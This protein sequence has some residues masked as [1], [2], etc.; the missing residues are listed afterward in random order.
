MDTCFAKM[1]LRTVSSGLSL[2][3]GLDRQLDLYTY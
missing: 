2:E 1:E 3:S